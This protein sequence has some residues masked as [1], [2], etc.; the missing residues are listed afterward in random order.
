M[1]V[2][3]LSVAPVRSAAGAVP[4]PRRPCLG[5]AVAT[6]ARAFLRRIGWILAGAVLFGLAAAFGI[7]VPR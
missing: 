2:G 7:D 3:L 4:S 5:V 1:G 6:I